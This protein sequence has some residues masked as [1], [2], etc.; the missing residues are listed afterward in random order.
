MK[1]ENDLKSSPRWR[2]LHH[3]ELAWPRSWKYFIL[4]PHIQFRV[5][6]RFDVACITLWL[7]YSSSR[8]MFMKMQLPIDSSLSPH[9]SWHNLH[10]TAPTDIRQETPVQL[11]SVFF[12]KAPQM[13]WPADQE[14]D[15]LCS[16]KIKLTQIHV[17]INRL[18]LRL[19]NWQ[20]YLWNT[21]GENTSSLSISTGYTLFE[22]ATPLLPL[23]KQKRIP[24]V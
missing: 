8:E 10:N 14:K 3:L 7:Q 22:V 23:W 24:P 12:P 21:S 11:L 13:T 17:A 20:C 5:S 9:T 4:K 16:S 19:D 18:T 1:Q 15:F 2:A 6:L